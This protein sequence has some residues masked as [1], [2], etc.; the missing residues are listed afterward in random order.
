LVELL[1]KPFDEAKAVAI[2]TAIYGLDNGPSGAWQTLEQLNAGWKEYGVIE[3]TALPSLPKELWL[4]NLEQ[5]DVIIVGGGNNF[6]LS[7][8]MQEAE[9]F[10]ILPELLSDNR[11][12][13]LGV[14]AGGG[15]L[16]KSFNVDREKLEREGVYYDDEYGETGPPGASSAKTME[17]VS[18]TQRPHMNA[19]YFPAASEANMEEWAT[20]TKDPLY[21]YDDQTALR[22]ID[23]EVE[24]ISEGAWR[25]FN[26]D[27]R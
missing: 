9:M 7:Y 15:I 13:F 24:V 10:D 26:A 20:K 17:L 5:A 8:W 1:G 19:D 18:F 25:L 3:L 22:V 21:A 6:Y 27:N 4:S 12:V 14:S 16:T 11:K 23:G 2:P